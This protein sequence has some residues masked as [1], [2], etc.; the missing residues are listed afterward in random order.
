[1]NEPIVWTK[2]TLRAFIR[3]YKK[4]VEEGRETFTFKETLF[5]VSYAEYMIEYLTPRLS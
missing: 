5:S 3:E 1:M 4:A 2:A